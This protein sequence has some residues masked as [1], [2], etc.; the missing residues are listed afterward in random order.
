MSQAQ[1]FGSE[2]QELP[3]HDPR[4][5]EIIDGGMCVGTMP[6]SEH[7]LVRGRFCAHLVAWNLPPDLG[8][9]YPSLRVNFAPDDVVS[10]HVIWIGHGRGGRGRPPLKER[11]DVRAVVRRLKAS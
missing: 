11:A 6:G 2:H 3:A 8:R 1:R 10:P 4:R 5:R 7:R 9:A